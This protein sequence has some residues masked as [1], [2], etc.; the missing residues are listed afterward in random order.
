[1]LLCTTQMIRHFQLLLGYSHPHFLYYLLLW[2]NLHIA[3][4]LK[5]QLPQEDIFSL[6]YFLYIF[7]YF[8]DLLIILG[9][10]V[11]DYILHVIFDEEGLS[12]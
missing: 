11:V 5:V 12:L 1:M 7:L 9:V 8:E 3:T 10:A 4:L 2:A 6:L